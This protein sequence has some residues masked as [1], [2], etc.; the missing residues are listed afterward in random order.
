MALVL[1]AL[2]AWSVCDKAVISYYSKKYKPVPL[3][4]K[5][6]YIQQDVNI[7]VPTID[8]EWTFTECMRLWLESNPREIVI[9]TVERNKD[10]I[11]RLVE[12]LKE[13]ADR[14]VILCAPLANKHIHLVVGV[15]A[16]RGSI[17]AL[18]DDDVYWR[19]KGVL[20]YLL[21]PFED[22]KVGAHCR[23]PAER[24]S[25]RVIT[26]WGTTST[27]DLCQWKGSR[28]VH[29][30]ADGGCWCLSARTLLIRA[31][32]L[33]DPSFVKA[34]TQQVIGRRVVNTADDVVLTGWIFDRGWKVSIQ[35]VPEAEI[36]TNIP[37]DQRFAWQILRWDRG[38]FRTFLGYI[39]MYPGYRKMMQ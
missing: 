5:S 1:A 21:A 17:L 31:S 6:N 22:A 2:W 11:V 28:E 29:F 39:F 24:Q 30:A 10:R 38:N 35:N 7:I 36:T 27:F 37:Q 14:I 34:Y 15:K 8:T 20:P 33:Q 32:I 23:D 19:A 26:A 18:V 13:N 4:K 9:V 25:S 16:A 3:P 12:P